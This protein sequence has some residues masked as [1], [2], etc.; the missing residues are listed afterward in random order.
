MTLTI[1]DGKL[2]VAVVAGPGVDSW[3]S[4]GVRALST[5]CAEMG[6]SVGLYGGESLT[7]RG[8]L[9][10]PGTGGIVLVED[11]QKRVHR[12]QTRAVV[13]VSPDVSF[14]DPFP[15]W[16]S[17]CL[18]PFSTA[19]RLWKEARMAWNPSTVI[20]GS[21]NRALRFGSYLLENGIDEAYCIE[22]YAQWGAKRFAG[23][24]VERRRFEMLGGRLLEA[25]PVSLTRKSA[26]VWEFRVRDTQGVRIL[27]TA[28]VVS[29][30]PFRDFSGV[31]EHPPGSLLFE[32]DQSADEAK[33]NDV[34]G[35]VLEEERGRWL[36]AKIVRTLAENLG[37]RREELDSIYR[38]ARGRLKRYLRHREQPFLPTYQGKWLSSADSRAITEFR[39]TP[40]RELATR[41]IASI[42]C[43][44]EI[45]CNV[46]QTVCPENAIEIGHIPRDKDAIL[47]ESKCSGCGICVSACPSS[48]ILMI[49]A[50][51]KKSTIELTLPATGSRRWSQG[52]FVQL[53][54]RRG[55]SLGS[56]RILTIDT[57]QKPSHLK[58]EA[59][60]HLAWEAR[61]FRRPRTQEKPDE[62][63]LSAEASAALNSEKVEITLEGEKRLVRDGIPVSLALFEIGHGRPGDVLLCK[64]GSCGLC[65]LDVDGTRK[66][67]CQEKIHQGMAIKLGAPEPTPERSSFLCPCLGITVED[68]AQKLKQGKIQTAEAALSTAHVGE[69]RCHG[70]LCMSAFKRALADLDLDASHWVDW[71]F[72]WSDWPVKRN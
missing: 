8:V 27:E 22:S 25:T 63:F 16:R 3:P 46:C 32:L 35:W 60:S 2:D 41:P 56:G 39:G 49:Q 53:L 15:G 30:G 31:R 13:R 43:F 4:A 6:L 23:W 5:L 37:E 52:E 50:D 29:V 66:R 71:R 48:A 59:P 18:V 68:L 20:L 70:R 42:E 11:S 26:L 24:E 69:G 55:D 65:A 61:G 21:G 54:N 58:I 28:R 45:P 57:T 12:I 14:P 38:R 62:V 10:V 7:V 64:D 40:K 19:K 34:E 72:P 17:Q 67:G 51:P 1:R 9:P 36:G 47:I 44:E 33:V